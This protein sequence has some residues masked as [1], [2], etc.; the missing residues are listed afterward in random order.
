VGL[1]LKG[2]HEDSWV[3]EY[4]L[5]L[6]VCVQVCWVLY[7]TIVYHWEKLGKRMQEVSIL[8]LAAVN[9]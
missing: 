6:K 2:Q 4:S 1:A 5:N 3:M 9:L 8:F 7:C